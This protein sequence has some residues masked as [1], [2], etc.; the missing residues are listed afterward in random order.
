V[1]AEA[2]A[3]WAMDVVEALVDKSLVAKLRA[4]LGE[5]G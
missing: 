4:A 2:Q 5:A 1:W 3:G